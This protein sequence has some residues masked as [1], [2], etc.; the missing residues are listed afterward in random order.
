MRRAQQ[1]LIVRD[2][3]PPGNVALRSFIFT[4]GWISKRLCNTVQN[5]LRSTSQSRVIKMTDP[6]SVN[7]LN[8]SNQFRLTLAFITTLLIGRAHA[9]QDN[10]FRAEDWE[11]HDASPFV[12]EGKGWP[13]TEKPF[14]RLPERVKDWMPGRV[15]EFSTYSTGL[16]LRFVT[17]ASKI[18][19]HWKVADS[20]ARISYMAPSGVGGL[21]LYVRHDNAWHWSGIGLPD[22]KSLESHAIIANQLAPGEHEYLLYLPLYSVVESLE[23]GLPPG[24]RFLEPP[25][26]DTSRK[27]ICFYGTSIIQG[28]CAMRPGTCVTAVIGRR[29]DRSVINL[30]FS[31]SGRMEPEL[32][33]LLVE[34]D[35]AV[36]VLDCLPNLNTEMM[37]DRLEPFVKI[38]RE[39]RPET[40]MVLVGHA[41]LGPDAVDA[42]ARGDRDMNRKLEAAFE[43]LQGEGVKNLY[44]LKGDSIF[45]DDGEGTVD[46]VHPTDLG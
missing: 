29:L 41:V 17:D 34:L 33:K 21:D 7:P 40:P 13:E 20:V 46:G 36:Y 45:G 9:E 18:A 14:Q 42:S 44:Y 15:W 35:P 23:I 5:D 32:A 30:G 2:A 43:R 10:P 27:P 11:W 22:P 16:A 8:H 26:R 25:R 12:T 3:E 39:G 31:G 6:R 1:F 24:S 38:M 4:W 28:G 19:A 37:V